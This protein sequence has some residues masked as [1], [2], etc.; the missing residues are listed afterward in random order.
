MSGLK[1]LRNRVHSIK[2][3]QKITKAMQLV[4]ASKLKKVKDK[5]GSFV[6]YSDI[7]RGMMHDISINISLADLS[8]SYRPFFVDNSS[9]LGHLLVVMTSERG[10]CGSFN[11]SI[12]RKVKQDI[13]ELQASGRKVKLLI[14]GKKGIDAFKAQYSE[15][16]DSC[17]HDIKGQVESLSGMIKNKIMELIAGNKVGE[18]SI[19]YNHF[20]NAMSQIPTRRDI[21]PATFEEN[22]ANEDN[23][24]E[25][26]GDNVIEEILHLY[27]SGEI[28]NALLQSKASEEGA[29][30]TAM[31]NA[32][33]NA[34]ELVNKLTLQ[35]NRSR[36]AIITKELIEIISG[37]EAV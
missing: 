34:G 16:I 9:G 26:E 37:A 2:S 27:I 13:K 8:E 25:Y 35:L 11:A 33:R 3:T 14:I 32:T 30:M 29:R 6:A 19:Y 12:I 20:K 7:L 4:S 21:I 17:Y 22:K 31:D 28:S 36:Q 5:A 24:L 15:I 23:I 10:L 18:C 1:Q